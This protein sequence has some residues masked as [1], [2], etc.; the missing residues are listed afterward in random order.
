MGSPSHLSADGNSKWQAIHAWSWQ[1]TICRWSMMI[2]D[3]I[4]Y[5]SPKWEFPLAIFDDQYNGDLFSAPTKVTHHLTWAARPRCESGAARQTTLGWQLALN[6]FFGTHTQSVYSLVDFDGMNWVPQFFGF[7]VVWNSLPIQCIFCEQMPLT[8]SCPP[9]EIP[10]LLPTE[11]SSRNA[12]QGIRQEVVSRNLTAVPIYTRSYRIIPTIEEAPHPPS[13]EI[14]SDERLYVA[15]FSEVFM[16][17]GWTACSSPRT[18]VLIVDVCCFSGIEIYQR[19]GA[20]AALLPGDWS[21]TL[22]FNECQRQRQLIWI[23]LDGPKLVNYWSDVMIAGL[24]S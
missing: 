1:S 14:W 9:L 10:V 7:V 15:W 21:R 5:L 3:D 19:Y 2:Y 20:E 23:D 22:F 13:H 8:R 12:S 24:F 16:L 4:I 18:V 6:L 11:C 17:V